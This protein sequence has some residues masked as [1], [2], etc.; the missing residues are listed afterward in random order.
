[1]EPLPAGLSMVTALDVDDPRAPRIRLH[2]PRFLAAPV[3]DPSKGEWSS[4]E[5]MLASRDAEP[6]TGVRGA[7]F[8][9]PTPP[10]V[11]EAF[12]TVASSFIAL[13]AADRPDLTPIWRFAD[14]SPERWKW[15][16][17]PFQGP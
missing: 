9:D 2:R 15:E 14:G 11:P 6:G 1:V 8:I 13:P 5:A 12:G 7:L 10:G 17:V 16:I 4:W 3:P